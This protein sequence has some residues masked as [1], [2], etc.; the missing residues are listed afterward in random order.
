MP[1]W[2]P[3]LLVDRMKLNPCL[4]ISSAAI[5]EFPEDV[6]TQDQ[7]RQGAVLLHVL[8]V[9]ICKSE[10]IKKE[11]LFCCMNLTNRCKYTVS[12]VTAK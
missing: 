4:S 11:A 1:C 7:R 2:T 10:F 12:H 3:S 6:F 8:C 5:S 9:S